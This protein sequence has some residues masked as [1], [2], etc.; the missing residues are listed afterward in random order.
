MNKVLSLL[1][2]KYPEKCTVIGKHAHGQI[3]NHVLSCMT[4]SEYQVV[5]LQ[6][7]QAQFLRLFSG[8]VRVTQIFVLQG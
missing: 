1:V 8:R 4:A 6:G 5:A 3:V 7:S 2:K